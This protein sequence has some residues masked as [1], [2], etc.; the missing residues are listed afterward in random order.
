M[1]VRTHDALAPLVTSLSEV[2]PHP[3]NPRVGDTA[4][5]AESVERNGLYRPLIVQ[6]GTGYVLAGNHLLAV[7]TASGATEAPVVWI[8]CTD[9]EAKRILAAD[10]GI[11]AKG[12]YDDLLLATLLQDLDDLTGTGYDADDL[13]NL[14]ATLDLLPTATLP[15][16]HGAEFAE[17]DA[18][19]AAR[20][21]AYTDRPGESRKAEGLREM[22]LVLAN[23]DYNEGVE[24]IRRLRSV[25]GD[26]PAG[27]VV[28]GALRESSTAHGLA[29][30]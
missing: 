18:E 2:R 24:L 15:E 23:D 21:A 30:A 26:V 29:D 12:S 13:D 7:L 27:V 3:D 25:F 11:A 6:R 10:N 19:H 22:W 17:S 14:L 28:L 1:D 8:D 5:I 9:E 4:A 20:A 16:D